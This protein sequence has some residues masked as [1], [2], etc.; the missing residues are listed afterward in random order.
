MILEFA[1]HGNLKNYLH[2]CKEVVEKLNHAPQIAS[3][4]RLK[5]HPSVNS[6]RH[7]SVNSNRHASASS[8]YHQHEK[9][10]LSQQ[11]SVFSVSSR[12]SRIDS[13]DSSSPDCPKVCTPRGRYDSGFCGESAVRKVKG[14]V[15]S[16]TAQDYV[17]CKGLL[18]M[19]DVLGFGLQIARGL[20]HLESLK[21][22]SDTHILLLLT[23]LTVGHVCTLDFVV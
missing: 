6:N 10:P 11:S 12:T 22:R 4:P 15:F 14:S 8:F 13:T 9:I 18:Y 7:P 17:N 1:E 20:Q 5:R 2:Q 23:L 21:V 19:E 3:G 16:E